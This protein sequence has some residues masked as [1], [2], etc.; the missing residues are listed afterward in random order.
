[1]AT[2]HDFPFSV[3]SA[4]VR[5]LVDLSLPF[6]HTY[7][8]TTQTAESSRNDQ[9]EADTLLRKRTVQLRLIRSPLLIQISMTVGCKVVCDMFSFIVYRQITV[10]V[11]LL[12]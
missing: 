3:G 10:N 9:Q 1:M 12:F 6:I 2:S 5:T 4:V 11:F 7:I 8:D